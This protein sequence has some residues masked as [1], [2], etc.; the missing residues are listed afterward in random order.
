[1]NEILTV[2]LIAALLLLAL[3]CLAAAAVA[4][5][6]T[7]LGRHYR[8][9]RRGAGLALPPALRRLRVAALTFVA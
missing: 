7:A 6:I 9:A 4:A 5:A 3:L 2:S 1:M 8:Q